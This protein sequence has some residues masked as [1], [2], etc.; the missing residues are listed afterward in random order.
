MSFSHLENTEAYLKKYPKHDDTIGALEY[1][2]GTDATEE[3]CKQAL[4]ENKRIVLK[5][6]DCPDWIDYKLK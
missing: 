3:L 4:K 1:A 5:T 2:I 6:N